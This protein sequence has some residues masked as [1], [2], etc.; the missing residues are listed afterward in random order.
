MA[1]VSL[2]YMGKVN[3][4]LDNVRYELFAKKSKTSEKL[5]PT[6]DAFDH[7]L[8]RAN[9][10]AYIWTHATDQYLDIC[11]INN[12]WK[13]H[14]SGH[15]VVATRPRVVLDFT[16]CGCSGNCSSKRCKCRKEDLACTDGRLQM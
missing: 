5:P 3:Y 1:L 4:S 10:Q 14:E 6:M 15:L 11:P 2:M 12:G 16:L 8:H 9:F 13:V 7:H